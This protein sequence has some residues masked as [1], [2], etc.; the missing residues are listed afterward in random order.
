MSN[1]IVVEEPFM[2]FATH[3]HYPCGGWNDFKDVFATV[4]EARIRGKAYLADGYDEYHVVDV[5]TL[6]EVA[7][8]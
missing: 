2:L 4:E 6:E 7:A 8:G 3:N 1:S 5:G